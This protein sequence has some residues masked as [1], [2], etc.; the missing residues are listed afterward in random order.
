MVHL[1]PH[2]NW[3]PGQSVDV[4]AYTNCDEVRLFLN[5]QPVEA[6]KMMPERKLSLRWT[7]P[8]TAGVLRAEG[9]RNGRLVA[10]DTVRTAGD[11]V[12]IVLSADKSRLLADNQDLSF[13]TVKVTDVDGTL[14]PTADHL[15]LFEIAGQGKIAGVGNGD[16]VSRESCKGRQ[17]HA[18]N[19]LCQV[20]LQS[21]DTKGRI[22]LKASSLGLADAKIT[23]LTE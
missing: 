1:L 9:F 15:V 17:R 7:L 20:V 8:F 23:V 10:V 13:V 6:K 11:A 16:P 4:I 5:E 2:W 19:G 12:K 18:F 14:C 3:R 22:E 21:T